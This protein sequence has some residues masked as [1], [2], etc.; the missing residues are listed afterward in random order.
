MAAIE[1]DLI[2]FDDASHDTRV[3]GQGISR[4]IED[5]RVW[6]EN[7]RREGAYCYL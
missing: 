1:S 7:T 5:I 6:K 4:R 3:G 2:L